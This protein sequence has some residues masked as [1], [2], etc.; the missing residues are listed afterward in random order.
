MK[1]IIFGVFAIISLS[2]FARGWEQIK[3]NGNLKK[4]T[5]QAGNFSALS[6]SGSMDVIISYG[7]SSSI[8]VEA[9]DN[10][11]PY[12]E[13]KLEGNKLVIRS[14]DKIGLSSKNKMTIRV[15][16]TKVENLSV[17]GSGD[18]K[19]D[20]AFTNEGKTRLAIAGSGSINLGFSHFGDVDAAISGSGDITIKNGTSKNLDAHVSGSGKV[21]ASQIAFD[22]VD[23][24][25]SGSGDVKTKAN[26]SIDAHIS[27]SGTLYYTG[28]ATNISTKSS[29]SGKVVKM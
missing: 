11:L 21:D 26:K 24:H 17:A 15:Q 3:G 19:G 29:G 28:S 18:I 4:E 5:R 16:M 13:T 14:K 7:S 27:G 25:I 20:G 8:E 9:D 23:A 10:L 6:S 22:E 2:V 12:I 1:K